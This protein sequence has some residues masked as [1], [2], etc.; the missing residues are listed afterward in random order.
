MGHH[1]G[2]AGGA[3]NT[4]NVRSVL[5]DRVG[6]QDQKGGVGLPKRHHLLHWGDA[7]D[8]AAATLRMLRRHPYTAV[9]Q[10]AFARLDCSARTRI[11]LLVSSTGSSRQRAVFAGLDL[12]LLGAARAR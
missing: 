9:A 8:K 12:S 5:R 7:L 6:S 4:R 11:K 2:G 1:A 3:V 10:Q